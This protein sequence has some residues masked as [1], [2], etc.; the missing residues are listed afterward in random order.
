MNDFSHRIGGARE[1]RTPD[2]YNAIVA[3]SQLS[4]GPTEGRREIVGRH[5]EGVNL[6]MWLGV[7]FLE[8]HALSLRTHLCAVQVL[9]M[10][11]I[12]GLSGSGDPYSREYD[13]W[14]GPFPIAGA[15]S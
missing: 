13:V 8:I 15:V 3:L 12:T 10:N 4:Y 11:R 1:D 6:A 5:L 14:R 9:R 7:G 2:L